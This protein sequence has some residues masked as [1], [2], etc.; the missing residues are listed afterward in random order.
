MLQM[1][2]A[3]GVAM[4]FHSGPQNVKR[5]VANQ[6][7]AGMKI[8]TMNILFLSNMPPNSYILLLTMVG[9]ISLYLR[10]CLVTVQLQAFAGQKIK[11]KIIS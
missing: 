10:T 11:N 2:T 7:N 5:V 6:P 3:M 8:E 4:L 9:S 1:E